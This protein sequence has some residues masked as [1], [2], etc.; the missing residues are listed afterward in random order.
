LIINSVRWLLPLEH[1]LAVKIKAPSHLEPGDSTLLNATV[2]NIGIN[3]E[4]VVELRLLINDTVVSSVMILELLAGS[5][6]TLSYSWTPMAE[7]TYNIT[8]YAPPVPEEEFIANNIATK[9]VI[10]RPVKYVLF[11]QTHVTEYMPMWYKIWVT[12]LTERGY[13]VD[14]HTSGPINV[15]VLTGYDVFVIPRACAPYDLDELWAIQNFVFSGGG[16]LVIGDDVPSIYTDLTSFAGIT[17]MSGGKSG[18]TSDITPHEVT[19]GV[20][21]V[22]L[23]DPGAML[24]IAAPAQD[25]VRDPSGNFMLAVSLEHVIGFADDDSL[26]DLFITLGDNLQLANNMIDWLA[27]TKPPPPGTRDVAIVDVTTSTKKAYAGSTVDVTVTAVN[28]GT[29]TETFAVTAYYDTTP[30]GTQTIFSLAPGTNITITI[31][32]NTKGVPPRV[33]YTIWAEAAAVPGET[34]TADNKLT[35]GIVRIKFMGDINDDGKVDIKD[36][37]LLIKAFGSYSS[38]P[39]WNSNADFNGDGKVDIKDLILL[40]KN[41]GRIP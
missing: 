9:L 40:L 37:Q 31:S 5:S 26:R 34:D 23:H 24:T 35:D 8:A 2:S 22:Y 12:D 36:L 25:L 16:L 7:G 33:N 18:F 14:A 19:L 21:S 11:D 4:T 3:D 28:E 20:S 15:T 17:W 39:R 41:F 27:A 32:W 30:I 10:V 13:I 6:Y 38:H 1:D 29:A